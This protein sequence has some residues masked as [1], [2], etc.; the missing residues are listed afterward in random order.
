MPDRPFFGKLLHDLWGQT[1]FHSVCIF[2]LIADII[3][4]AV[5]IFYLTLFSHFARTFLT[6]QIP[7]NRFR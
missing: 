3:D 4:A 5:D 2:F 6:V 7:Q 1:F